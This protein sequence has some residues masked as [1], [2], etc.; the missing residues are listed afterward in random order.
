MLS[1]KKNQVVIV[2]GASTGIGRDCSRLL[3]EHNF[4]VVACVRSQKD[5][6]EVSAL[7]NTIAVILDVTQE[8]DFSRAVEKLRPVLDSADSIHLVNNAGIAVS[9]PV[10]AVSISEWK[11]QFDV[12]VFGLVRATQVF[13]PWIRSSRGA[14]INIGSISGKIAMPFVAPYA[15][16]K[17]A[18]E[19]I[20]DSLRR[21]LK[22]HGVRVV[23]IE[24]GPID[25]PIWS[26]GLS[27]KE[28]ILA[29]LSPELEALYGPSL[30]RF[31][32]E[33]EKSARDAV[34]V[35]TVSQ[36][37]LAALERP[38]PKTRIVVG[39]S[40]VHVIAKL[41]K[42]LPDRILDRMLKT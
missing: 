33:V 29:T 32:D 23:L 36:S 27:K 41:S 28:T 3:A 10:E 11:K 25:T 30:G 21:E 37:V 42:F 22:E 5:F 8:S 20:S 35:A 2:T 17:F 12:N 15:A 40:S 31:V 18:V 7:K 39:A 38:R 13:L 6:D 14:I 16:S 19:A 4:Q 26:K 24:P 34:P 1:P 9:G